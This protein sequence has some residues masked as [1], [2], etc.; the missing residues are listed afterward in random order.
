MN[1]CGVFG[2]AGSGPVFSRT[3]CGIYDLQHRGEQGAGISV[4]DGR[5]IETYRDFGLVPEVFSSKKKIE[6]EGNLA[7]GHT[8][9]STIGR[10]GEE[11][12]E[13]SIQPHTGEFRGG[14]FAISF[15]GNLTELN[16]LREEAKAKGFKF[17]S[18]SSDTEVMVALLSVSEKRYFEEALLEVLPRLTGA[19]ALVILYQDR[20][21]GIR[22]SCGIRPLCLGRDDKNFMLAS[23]S[24]AFHTEGGNFIRDIRPG[25]I[26]ILNPDGIENDF[27][28]ADDSSL[29]ICIVEYLYF[30]RPDS[31]IDGCNVN[32]Y[33][34]E[35]SAG[36]VK[37]RFSFFCS[38][39]RQ[40]L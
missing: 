16:C 21:I 20:V 23:E 18:E 40:G 35:A 25:E 19:F 39:L 29:N 27:Q 24:C 14:Q 13:K 17:Q 32:N 30:A 37:N 2:I 8:L 12:Q 9:Y 4:S 15:N 10:Q 36:S 6:L 28:W 3:K 31:T 33:R 26:I 11:K 38:G 7:I 22:D 34:Y 5:R 1:M